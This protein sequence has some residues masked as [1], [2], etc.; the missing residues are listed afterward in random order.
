MAGG[1]PKEFK[2][3]YISLVNDY[4]A[5]CEDTFDKEKNEYMVKLPTV[6][7]FAL[8]I[9]HHKDT[10]YEWCKENKLFS[11]AID[12]IKNN[13]LNK[14]I[15]KGL[16]GK[17]NPTIA[18]LLLSGNHNIREKSDITTDDKKI[19]TGV[20]ILPIRNENKMETTT[21]TGEGSSQ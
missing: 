14:L 7:G 6:E 3:T 12:E 1:R 2:E 20:V 13:Q 17:Y 4:I 19:E 21:E 5:E 8:F 11:D 9:G 15:N 10:I 16:S 18:K